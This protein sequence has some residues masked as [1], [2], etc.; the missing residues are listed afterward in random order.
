[1][2]SPGVQELTA[3]TEEQITAIEWVDEKRMKELLKNSYPLISD[4]LVQP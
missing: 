3:Q 1:M 4:M 2:S